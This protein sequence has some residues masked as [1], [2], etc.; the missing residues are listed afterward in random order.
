MIHGIKTGKRHFSVMEI[1]MLLIALIMICPLIYQILASFK[2]KAEVSRPLSLPSSFY[3][4]NY[5][6]TF[7]TA[8]FLILLKNSILVSVISISII[9]LVASIASY[10]LSRSK[11]PIYKFVYFYFLSG[12]MVPF[13]AG[14]IP[15]YRMMSTLDLID[16]VASLI[17]V[18]VGSFIPMSILIYTGFIKTVPL[19][20]E[21]SAVI[22]GCGRVGIFF[23]IVFPLLKPAT[24]SVIILSIIPIWNDFLTPLIFIS[25]VANKTLPVGLF[26]FMNLRTSNMGPIFAFGI[27]ASVP[28]I[29]LFLSL[30][31]YF[32]KGI[33]TGAIKG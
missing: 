32:Y 26:S 12:L 33:V 20:L 27:L 13:Q 2:N 1:M 15:L 5:I 28:P 7:V 16:S 19:E 11:K 24:I 18:S 10:P 6:E 22:D 9:I 8:K 4:E 31:K 21:E 17:F 30:Q 14:M 3:I 25:R 23:R 29:V